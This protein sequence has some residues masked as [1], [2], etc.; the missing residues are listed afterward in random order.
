MAQQEKDANLTGL[1]DLL[2]DRGELGTEPV[3]EFRSSPRLG[4]LPPKAPLSP[5]DPLFARIAPLL[6]LLFLV[7]SSSGEVGEPEEAAIR[8]VARTLNGD[9]EDA[10]IHLLFKSFGE[11]LL[12]EGLEERVSAVTMALSVDRVSAESAY[13]LAATV[14][15]A[16]GEVSQG[17]RELLSDIAVQLGISPK[18]ARELSGHPG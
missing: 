8:G 2:V 1:R 17:E 3:I 11:A 12:L 6:E 14:A 18:R 5:S 9:L 4:S 7:R 16:N 13:T 10:E 15:V